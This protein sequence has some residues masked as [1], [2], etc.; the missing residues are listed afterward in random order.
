MNNALILDLDGCLADCTARLDRAKN[1]ETGKINWRT[2]YEGM[3]DD[4]LVQS[5]DNLTGTFRRTGHAVVII[6][7]R[8]VSYDAETLDWL[9][10]NDVSFAEIHFRPA[11]D[12]RPAP[13]Y[14]RSVFKH[15]IAP[16]FNVKL[17]IDDDKRIAEMWESEGIPCI[18]PA[19]LA[20]QKHFDSLDHEAV[21]RIA[22]ESAASAVTAAVLNQHGLP[23]NT[24]IGWFRDYSTKLARS[25]AERIRA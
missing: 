13:V 3:E 16:Y 1:P 14:K 12:F 25:V 2:F 19:G 6:T 9:K 23:D 22:D 4:V 15:K 11:D 21:L 10:K 7:G 20:V 17:A 18:V 5:V 24:P 8:P